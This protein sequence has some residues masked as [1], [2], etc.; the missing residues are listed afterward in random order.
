MDRLRLFVWLSVLMAL[1]VLA[2]A[3]ASVQRGA[4]T[5]DGWVVLPVTEYT[6]LKRAASPAEPEPGS[7][8]LE[9][10]VTRIDYNLQIDGDLATG[11]ARLTVDRIKTGCVR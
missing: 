10:T 9:A 3:P 6:A 8:P 7:P 2:G 4:A 5:P 1:A 11:E